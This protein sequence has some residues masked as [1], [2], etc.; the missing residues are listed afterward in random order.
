ML[1]NMINIFCCDVPTCKGKETFM[2]AGGDSEGQQVMTPPKIFQKKEGCA[3]L[4]S[5]WLNGGIE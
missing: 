4:G 3:Y 1:R 5:L 2:L